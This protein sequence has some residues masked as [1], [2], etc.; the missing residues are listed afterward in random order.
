MPTSDKVYILYIDKYAHDGVRGVFTNEEG[1]VER[2]YFNGS[3]SRIYST[4]KNE[5]WGVIVY[6]TKVPCELLK[7]INPGAWPG[8]ASFAPRLDFRSG[9]V[10]LI[11]APK[12]IDRNKL[13]E[14]INSTVIKLPYKND[15]D[16][17]LRIFEAH[18]QAH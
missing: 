9:D 5:G 10:A 18:K 3:T 16:L 8:T 13:V 11:S 15:R 7:A 2:M 4:L 12:K 14:V 17:E 6:N 1:E